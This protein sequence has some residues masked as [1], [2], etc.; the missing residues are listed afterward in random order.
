VI[1]LAD[2]CDEVHEIEIRIKTIF[3]DHSEGVVFSS[4]HK[5]KGLEAKRVY[6]LEPGL[7]PHPMAKKSWEMTQEINIKYV[8]YTR[9]LD[10]LVFVKD[11]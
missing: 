8:A 6:I 2:G 4:I 9:S 3:S 1:A 5:A 10:T 11:V 7:M